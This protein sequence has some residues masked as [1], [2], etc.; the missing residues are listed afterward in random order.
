MNKLNNF[1]LIAKIPLLGKVI[2]RVVANQVQ[3]YLEEQGCLNPFWS[4]FRL[5]RCT[6][7]TLVAEDTQLYLSISTSAVEAAQLLVSCLASVLEWTSANRL[8]LNLDETEIM[9]GERGLR[10]V[11]GD[12]P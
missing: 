11:R 9:P 8:R 10:K 1:H 7:T 2:E 5:H 3:T 6:E 12:C 4:G